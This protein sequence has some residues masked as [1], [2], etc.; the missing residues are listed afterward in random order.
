[1]PIVEPCVYSDHPVMRDADPQN[2]VVLPPDHHPDRS[3]PSNA[4]SRDGKASSMTDVPPRESAYA[5]E[6]FGKSAGVLVANG[7]R[8][9]FWAADPTF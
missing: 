3:L 6:T 2:A 9:V 4:A 8:F 5:I 7:D 1:M